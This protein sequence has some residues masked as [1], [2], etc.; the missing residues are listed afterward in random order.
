MGREI[1]GARNEKHGRDCNCPT[2]SECF[3][4]SGTATKLYFPAS[5]TDSQTI[6]LRSRPQN[7]NRS[8]VCCL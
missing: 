3:L 2:I 1:S 7:A 8:D 6:Y 5:L 4:F